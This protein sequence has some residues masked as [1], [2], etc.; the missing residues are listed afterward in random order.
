LKQFLDPLIDHECRIEGAAKSLSRD[1]VVR[2]T[3]SPGYYDQP[4]LL[5]RAGD[6]A[7]DGNLVIANRDQM[8]DFDS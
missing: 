6:L 1:I 8:L 3:E 4:G 7:G 2:G 5:H